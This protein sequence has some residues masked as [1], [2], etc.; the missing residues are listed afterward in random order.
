MPQGYDQHYNT[1]ADLFED[2]IAYSYES[3]Y[4]PRIR[5]EKNGIE[6]IDFYKLTLCK[7]GIGAYKIEQFTFAPH[8]WPKIKK[9]AE[10][11]QPDPVEEVLYSEN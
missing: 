10:L 6:Y 3:A 4:P 2:R 5:T 7:T 11:L 8:L 1:F 9:L